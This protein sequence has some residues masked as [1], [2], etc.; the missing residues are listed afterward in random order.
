MFLPSVHSYFLWASILYITAFTVATIYLHDDD[1][2]LLTATKTL[3]WEADECAWAEGAE[4]SL[5]RTLT[6]LR[7]TFLLQALVGLLCF[8]A[9]LFSTGLKEDALVKYKMLLWLPGFICKWLPFLVKCAV[10]S[11]TFGYMIGTRYGVGIYD[12]FLRNFEVGGACSKS[13]SLRSMFVWLAS[14]WFFSVLLAGWARTFGRRPPWLLNPK[15]KDLFMPFRKVTRC[16]G[17]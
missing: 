8:F 14:L 11:I 2:F 12:H 3:E 1:L 13:S 6:V 7:W 15:R 10:I 5:S 17:P 9:Y 4:D 16:F